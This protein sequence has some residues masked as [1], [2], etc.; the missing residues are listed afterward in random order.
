[1][2]SKRVRWILEMFDRWNSG[3]VDG[4]VDALGPEFE[5]TPDPSFPDTGTYR[6]DEYRR[7][8]REWA[9]TWGDS[10]LEVLGTTERGDAVVV[11]SRWHLRAKTG[12]PIPLSD[13]NV[14]VWFDPNR[15]SPPRRAAAFFD[16]QRALE[17][18]DGTG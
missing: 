7:W 8:M 3:D 13:F 6:G 14:V 17:A 9:R 11:E 15:E 10:R 5:F 18:A 16:R 2:A 12:A 4:F 1:V